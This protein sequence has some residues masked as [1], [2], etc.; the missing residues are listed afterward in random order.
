MAAVITNA[1]LQ[2]FI[3]VISIFVVNVSIY[4][5]AVKREILHHRALN[6]LNRLFFEVGS[7]GSEA[8]NCPNERD[9]I[10]GYAR[11]VRHGCLCSGSW[12]H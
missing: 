3:V 7:V 1:I 10:V 8:D 4:I 11:S 5:N 9:F 2:G 6:V 12:W